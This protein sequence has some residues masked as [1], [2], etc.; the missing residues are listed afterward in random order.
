MTN[1]HITFPVNPLE[2]AIPSQEIQRRTV[3]GVLESYNSNYDVLAELIQNSVDAVED[4]FL[5]GLPEPFEIRVHINLQ[6]NWISVLD[7]G[8]GMNQVQAV[9]AFAPSASFKNNPLIVQKRGKNSYRGYKGVGLTFLAYGTDE[10]V[11]H[12]KTQDGFLT[13]G[14]MQYA[15]AW[16]MGERQEPA[17]II[18]DSNPSPL[19]DY[20]RGTFVKIQLSGKTRPKKLSL[21]ASDIGA[22][23]VILQA[24][25]AIGQ[26]SLLSDPVVSF[27]V[28][29]TLTD[30]SGKTTETPVPSTFLLPHLVERKPSFRFLDIPAY[31]MQH[32]ERT[33]IPINYLRQDGV[34]LVWDKGKIYE[35]L[36][37]KQKVEYKDEIE[38]YNPVLYA[39]FPYQTIAWKWI[40]E[41]LGSGEGRRLL[42]PGLIIG[43]NHQRLADLIKIEATRFTNL[44]PTLF[45]LMHFDNAKPDQGRKT[46]QDEVIALARIAA[47]RVLQYFQKQKGFLKPGGDAP[48]PGQREVEKNHED[49]KFNV[50]LHAKTNPLNIPPLTYQSKPL[51]EQDVVGLF[52]QLSARGVFP[53]LQIYATSQIKTYDSLVKFDC[54]IDTPGLKYVAV[55]DNPVGISPYI[56]GD[57]EVFSTRYL[58]LE[59]KNN[60]DALV[61][62]LNSKD[63]GNQKEFSHIDVCVCWSIVS[64]DFPG[65]SVD[66]IT[67]RNIDERIYPGA[68]HLLRKDTDSH[69]VQVV[70]LEKIVEMINNGRLTLS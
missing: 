51:T 3:A 23:K 48:T 34:Y 65:Y 11:L 38:A 18:E 5:A 26:I 60:L 8:L 35:E 24:R 7:T 28:M 9:D 20:S 44:A 33:D 45:V 50:Q 43:V 27:E 61:S 2:R 32:S 58:T 64:D 69:I 49:W 31:Y 30:T 47:D 57:S 41:A 19:D 4:A 1:S 25:T 13:K 63:N 56:L 52:N 29:L 14:V 66:E 54:P 55:D 6:D 22:W 15:R 21:I 67:P 40:N 59:F 37:V 53:G 62:E 10:V 39:F 16:A 70:L 68:T 12:T 36:T 17:L 42:S 46:V